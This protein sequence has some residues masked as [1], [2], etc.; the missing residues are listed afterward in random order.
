MSLDICNGCYVCRNVYLDSNPFIE[1]WDYGIVCIVH[2]LKVCVV[3][4]VPYIGERLSEGSELWEIGG[5]QRNWHDMVGIFNGLK[6][7]II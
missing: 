6:Q 2:N 7:I 4:V 1:N 5:D 3:L